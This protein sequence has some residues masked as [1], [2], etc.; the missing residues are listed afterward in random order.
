[1][2]ALP[3]LVHISIFL[4]LPLAIAFA[5]GFTNYDFSDAWSWVGLDN[6]VELFGDARFRR[7]L[8][9]TILYTLA[10]VPFAMAIALAVAIGL[11]QRIRGRATFRVLYYVPV[12]TATVAVAT[13]WMW[14]Y[15]PNVGL[16]NMVLG[17][18]GLGPV[19]W[20]ADTTTALPSIMIVGI[21]QGLGAKIVIYLAALQSVRRE[22]VEAAR[23]D[24]AG[25]WQAFRNVTW[26]ALRPVQFFVLVT[27]IISSFQVFDLVY[28]M[29]RGGPA[30]STVVLTYDIY[31]NAFHS[32]RLGYASAETM[33]AFVLIGTFIFIGL[34]VQRAHADDD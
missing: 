14:I 6:Y 13:V 26:P 30:D 31:H 16:G 24:G 4:A 9:N 27:S 34:K 23:V 29:T 3:G 17:F 12:V 33:M 7:A 28:V 15:N 5:L 10:V 20:L 21:W 1:V 25:S 2:L 8:L 22:L 19:R 11:N 32:L 18:F